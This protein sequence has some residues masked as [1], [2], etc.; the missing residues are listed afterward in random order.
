MM[1]VTPNELAVMYKLWSPLSGKG[2]LESCVLVKS[3]LP[4]TKFSRTCFF[5]KIGSCGLTNSL[6]QL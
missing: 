3:G 1:F 2:L 6:S 5:V 4:N